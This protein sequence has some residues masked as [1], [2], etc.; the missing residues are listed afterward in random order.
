[1]YLNNGQ[2]SFY[3]EDNTLVR[4]VQ[5]AQCLVFKPNVQGVFVVAVNKNEPLYFR[6]QSDKEAFEWVDALSLNGASK[7]D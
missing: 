2:F 7:K 5:A 4:H 6:C 3:L 1:V